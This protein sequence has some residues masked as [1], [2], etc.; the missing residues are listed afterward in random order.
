VKL[1]AGRIVLVD[2][3]DALPREASK[4]GRPAVVVEDEGLFDEA[5]PNVILVPLAEDPHLAIADLSVRIEPTPQNGC[6]KPCHALAHHVTATSKARI[7]RD[8]GSSVTADQLQRIR[9]L[10]ALSLAIEI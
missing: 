1:D 8:T 10:V 5:Y 9:R 4:R 6:A 2:W 3:R 7:L